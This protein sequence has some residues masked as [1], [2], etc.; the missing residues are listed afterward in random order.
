MQA[1]LSP[2]EQNLV[3]TTT[4][5]LSSPYIY[6][7]VDGKNRLLAVEKASNNIKA[8]NLNTQKIEVKYPGNEEEPYS[9]TK[10]FKNIQG[11]TSSVQ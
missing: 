2:N 4:K 1:Q 11:S 8:I 10:I 9:K 3:I 6:T 5:P 7:R